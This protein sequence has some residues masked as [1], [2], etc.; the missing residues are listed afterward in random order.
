MDP[1]GV[2]QESE[3]IEPA[4]VTVVSIEL[5]FNMAPENSPQHLSEGDIDENYE[6][7]VTPEI[8]SPSDV[9]TV[10]DPSWLTGDIR[11]DF[12]SFRLG[13][14][15][16][17]AFVRPQKLVEFVER[18]PVR[19]GE[20]VRHRRLPNAGSTRNVNPAH[21]THGNTL[22]DAVGRKPEISW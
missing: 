22:V 12:Q 2:S 19:F 16:A 4:G 10:C 17:G 6:V 9:H 13:D 8:L 20:L 5:G 18:E 15:L 1:D 3:Q 21:F 14:A 11:H 7:G